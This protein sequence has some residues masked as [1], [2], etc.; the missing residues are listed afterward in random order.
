[1]LKGQKLDRDQRGKAGPARDLAKSGRQTR[2]GFHVNLR[3]EIKRED[4]DLKTVG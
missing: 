4:D 3:F 1:M 2:D